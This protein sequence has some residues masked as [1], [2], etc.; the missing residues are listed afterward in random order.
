MFK[1]LLFNKYN[2]TICEI[3]MQT[4][5]NSVDSKLGPPEPLLWPY[6]GFKIHQTRWI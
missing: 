4:T 1:N 5:S 3:T 2:V 6:E